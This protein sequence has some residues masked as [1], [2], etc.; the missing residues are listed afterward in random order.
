VLTR[1]TFLKL[2]SMAAGSL[3]VEC[4]RPA[5]RAAAGAKVVM[6]GGGLSGI[7]AAWNL[8][9]QGYE[10][11]VLEA[12]AF[13]GGRVRTIRD[14]FK[15]GGYAEVGAVRIPN[16]HR[17]TLKYIKAMGLDSKLGSYNEDAGLRL[18][19]LQKKRFVTPKGEW[20]LEG[21]TSRE[22]ANPF[23]MSDEY[24]GEVLK[25]RG[26]PTKPEFPSAAA[27]ELD[28]LTV[29]DY[30]KRVGGSEEWCR[31]M[32]AAEGEVADWSALYAI[33]FDGEPADGPWTTTYGLIGGN[34][35]L[36]KAIASTLGS[37]IK[38]GTQ[39]LKLA[40]DPN[41]VTVTVRDAGGQH[42]IH[43]DYC[44]CGLP[45]P[46]LRDIEITP[47]F[48]DRK[49]QAIAKYRLAPVSR[50][51]Y[52]TKSRFWRKD[53]IGELGGLTLVG[54][55]TNAGRIWNTSQLQPDKTLGMIQSYMFGA[56]ALAFS[57]LPAAERFPKW[58]ELVAE[59]LP[60]IRDEVIAEAQKVWHEDPW[61]K[62]AFAEIQPH[63]IDYWPAS[64]LPE[65]RVHFAGEHT[66]L[67]TGWQNGAFDSAERC[68]REITGA[69]ASA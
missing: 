64:R 30:V 10:V 39:I 54:T 4:A 32:D 2:A 58:R 28:G 20:P 36:P 9:N 60:G 63:E 13:A 27:R 59:F 26:D 48:S 41:G 11:I 12:Q 66:S 51:C 19:Y 61:H 7:T 14:P 62:G 5:A 57:S 22:K 3:A 33:G 67:W 18:W 50:V 43:A 29:V 23:A 21:L 56:H 69:S 45:F 35:Q 68:V 15:N 31:L 17:F 65:G 24:F 16:N 52:Q 42:E 44:I 47:A 37:R 49:M 46:L 53:P 55:D 25:Q 8:M 40:H 34:D 1:R 38:Y 6:L